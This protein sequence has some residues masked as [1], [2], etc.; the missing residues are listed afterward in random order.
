MSPSRSLPRC[1]RPHVQSHCPNVYV[2]HRLRCLIKPQHPPA[3]SL[4]KPPTTASQ[5]KY[6][7]RLLQQTIPAA[8]P[9]TPKFLQTKTTIR[10]GSQRPPRLS[11]KPKLDYANFSTPSIRPPR[12]AEQ[13][14]CSF[15]HQWRS[16]NG[17]RALQHERHTINH[18]RSRP[19]KH[20]KLK[21]PNAR[22]LAL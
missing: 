12:F 18:H 3:L 16:K 21:L 20:I 8:K 5:P 2:N 14:G 15:Q 4:P 7:N 22:Q 6:R 17:I 13:H 11:T 19:P 1:L 10:H 9:W